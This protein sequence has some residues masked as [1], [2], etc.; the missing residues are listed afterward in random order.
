MNTNAISYQADRKT[1][2]EKI[3]AITTMQPGT[4]AEEWRERPAPNGEGSLRLG[5]YYK[6]QAWQD[7]RNVSRRVPT[8]EVAQLRE[9]TE[10]AKQFEHLTGELAKIT[11]EHTRILRASQADSA[12]CEDSKKNSSPRR[13]KNA[14]RKPKTSSPKPKKS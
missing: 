3:A 1:L 14:S 12:Q 9:D 10:N 8:S 4:L 7:G 13:G 5:P 11:I 2:L 6:H